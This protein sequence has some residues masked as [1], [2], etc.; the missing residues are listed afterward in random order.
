M[1]LDAGPAVTSRVAGLG[2]SAQ[3]T[4]FELATSNGQN[5]QFLLQ[6]AFT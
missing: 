2:C 6:V 3:E 5:V 4:M 1:A